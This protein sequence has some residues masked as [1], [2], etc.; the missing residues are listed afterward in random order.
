MTGLQLLLGV[1]SLPLLL[2]KI[3]VDAHVFRHSLDVPF[4]T[5]I[6]I[7]VLWIVAAL[8]LGGIAGAPAAA[9]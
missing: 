3:A 7:A 2:W 9:T 1:I 5:G 6:V 8:A 4:L